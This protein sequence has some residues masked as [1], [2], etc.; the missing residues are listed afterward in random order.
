MQFEKLPNFIILTLEE[1][2]RE[3]KEKISL[4]SITEFQA[5]SGKAYEANLGLLR[6]GTSCGIINT[7]FSYE[8]SLRQ[9]N[10]GE[11]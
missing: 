6:K 7:K 5:R 8:S 11:E 2:E 1:L 9:L 4:F 10:L 3:L